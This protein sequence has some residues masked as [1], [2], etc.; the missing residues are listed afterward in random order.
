MVKLF[1][2]LICSISLIL[3]QGHVLYDNVNDKQ[4]SANSAINFIKIGLQQYNKE[5]EQMVLTKFEEIEDNIEKKWKNLIGTTTKST[6]DEGW[7]TKSDTTDDLKA[8]K[9]KAEKKDSQ[10]NRL[11]LITT[12]YRSNGNLNR[13]ELTHL[14][15]FINESVYTMQIEQRLFKQEMISVVSNMFW[16]IGNISDIL[17]TIQNDQILLRQ[18]MVSVTTNLSE[19][20]DLL[21]NN[22]EISSL[23]K[24]YNGQFQKQETANDS[25]INS[26]FY[27]ANQTSSFCQKELKE[28]FKDIETNLRKLFNDGIDNLAFVFGNKIAENDIIFDEIRNSSLYVAEQLSSGEPIHVLRFLEK[29]GHLQNT[30][31]YN[32]ADILRKSPETRGNDGVYNIMDLN[33]IKAVYCEMSTDNG[34]WTVC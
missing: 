30:K 13:I 27:T 34:G 32:C 19:K 25:T 11:N 8:I 2:I 7:V 31:V 17:F 29:I 5:I 15:K 14:L 10:E 6:I 24:A 1:G 21:L 23:K 26:T 9:T 28:E 22:Q 20:V 18:N 16:S 33:E 12:E 3:M 4:S